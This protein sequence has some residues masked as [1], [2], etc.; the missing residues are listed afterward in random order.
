MKAGIKDR[1]QQS[2]V[3]S[4]KTTGTRQGVR[5]G[6]FTEVWYGGQER[7]PMSSRP[8]DFKSITTPKAISRHFHLVIRKTL[9]E[10]ILMQKRGI[11]KYT[12][13]GVR[14]GSF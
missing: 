10:L 12:M 8:G 6:L 3:R 2:E 4:Q 13:C 1:I 5:P 11:R 7:T 9:L 14:C